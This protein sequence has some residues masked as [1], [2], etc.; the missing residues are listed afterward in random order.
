MALT[1]SERLTKLL[2]FRT[3]SFKYSALHTTMCKFFLV[4]GFDHR[5]PVLGLG[6]Q[7]CR[8]N[9]GRPATFLGKGLWEQS[10]GGALRTAIPPVCL[11]LRTVPWHCPLLARYITRRPASRGRAALGQRCLKLPDFHT[12]PVYSGPG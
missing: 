11:S 1:C 9:L 2:S 12:R 8:E 5:N 7:G 4:E 6:C 3:N 10:P